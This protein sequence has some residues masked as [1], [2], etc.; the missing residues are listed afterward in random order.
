MKFQS[1]SNVWKITDISIY[2]QEEYAE[3]Q[4][5]CGLHLQGKHKKNLILNCPLVIT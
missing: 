5:L 2:G 1:Q 3:G 4:R